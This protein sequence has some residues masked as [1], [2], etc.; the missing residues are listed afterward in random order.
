M[1][2]LKQY[3]AALKLYKSRKYDEALKISAD[4]KFFFETL[5]L[6]NRSVRYVDEFVAR[7]DMTGLSSTQPQLM[8]AE[9]DR[10]LQ[11]MFPPRLLADYVRM[12]QSECLT[13][14]LTPQLRTN[15][16]VDRILYKIGKLLL[17]L[18]TRNNHRI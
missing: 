12:K 4:W 2:I 7:Y 10:V 14:Q 16:G 1:D 13:Q 11:A 8:R 9:K 18:R 3:E 17:R 15:Y 6:D 5:I